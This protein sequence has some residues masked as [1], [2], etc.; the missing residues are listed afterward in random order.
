MTATTTNENCIRH[1]QPSIHTPSNTLRLSTNVIDRLAGGKKLDASPSTLRLKTLSPFRKG[2]H[3]QKKGWRGILPSKVKL[4]M[5]SALGYPS[6]SGLRA[7]GGCISSLPGVCLEWRFVEGGGRRWREDSP[8]RPDEHTRHVSDIGLMTSYFSWLCGEFLSITDPDTF[9][10]SS[11]P[12][13][14]FGRLGRAFRSG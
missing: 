11:S 13:R 14:M 7:S 10:V 12:S 9:L 3:G 5:L 8:V 4:S 2:Q 6:R 1:L